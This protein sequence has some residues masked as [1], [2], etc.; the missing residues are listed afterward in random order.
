MTDT[1]PDGIDPAKYRT[2]TFDC[3]GTLIDWETGILAY[4]KPLF[5]GYDVHVIDEFV[6]ECYS[7]YEPEAQA[8]G[9]SYRA[10]LSKVL[11]RFGKRLA[12]TPKDNE[13]EGFADSIERWPAFPDTVDALKTL[14]EHFELAVVSNIDDDLFA[15][16]AK[17]LE[18]PFRHVI[19][20]GQIGVYKPAPAMFA[21]ALETV[22]SPVLHVAQSRFHDIV[23]ATAA[24]LDTVWIDRPSLGAARP[25]EA[26]PTWTFTS[27]A[28]FADSVS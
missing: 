24:G 21:A 15:M 4:L 1:E 9:G 8:E 7:R 19:T 3:Y 13:L 25:V 12:F 26:N 17:A 18:V 11:Q 28:E 6:L 14:S 2:L 10:V 20:A 27:L 16:S 23:P 22:E 5:E